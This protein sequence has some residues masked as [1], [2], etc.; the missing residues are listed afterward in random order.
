[1]TRLASAIAAGGIGLVVG[2]W[3]VALTEWGSVAWLAGVAVAA[4][5]TGSVFVCLVIEV[6]YSRREGGRTGQ[7]PEHY[8]NR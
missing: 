1:M 6:A 4:V 8:W 2:L 5:G 3:L 7:P